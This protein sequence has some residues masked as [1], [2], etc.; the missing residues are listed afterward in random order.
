[1]ILPMILALPAF[2]RARMCVCLLRGTLLLGLQPLFFPV[3]FTPPLPSPSLH[4]YHPAHLVMMIVIPI[5]TGL[6]V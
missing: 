1:M 5:P 4:S 6:V 2:P 3:L